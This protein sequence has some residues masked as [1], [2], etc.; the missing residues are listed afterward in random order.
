MNTR[1]ER[2]QYRSP[3]I[4]AADLA[5]YGDPPAPGPHTDAELTALVGLLTEPGKRIGT[6]AIGHSRD[7]HSRAAAEAFTTVWKARGGTVLAVVDW[8]E[9][10][11]SWLRPATRLTAELPDAWVMAAAPLGFAQLARRLR[12]S[13]D[14]DPA[15]S[16]AFASLRDSR[17]PALA[18][19]R[20]LDGLRGATADGG[21]WDVLSPC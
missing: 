19:A 12:H 6:V 4:S 13:T 21:T 14:W 5:A 18:G 9:A 7:R 10:A 2:Q 1:K 11:A 20:T 8:P 17:L 3:L 16:Y 15:R